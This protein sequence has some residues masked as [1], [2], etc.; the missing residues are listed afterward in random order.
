MDYLV[1]PSAAWDLVEITCVAGEDR[2]IADGT[3]IYLSGLQLSVGKKTY[4]IGTEFDIKAD[5]QAVT[6]LWG[7]DRKRQVR[8]LV[9]RTK[10]NTVAELKA[11]LHQCK[12][13]GAVQ[14]V[15]TSIVN[16]NELVVT[17]NGISS[18]PLVLPGTAGSA[19]QD[20]SGGNNSWM[21]ATGLG[22][23]LAKNPGS[24]L[25][26]ITI[27]DG[28]V[29][30]KVEVIGTV[31]DTGGS[32]GDLNVLFD[33][34]GTRTFN[35][36]AISA[37]KPSVQ[38][39]NGDYGSISPGSPSIVNPNLLYGVSSVGSGSLQVTVINATGYYTTH[40]LTFLMP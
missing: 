38:I 31:A 17:V 40:K 12:V 1:L 6:V 28:V 13:M 23:T 2:E 3:T 5:A 20:Y 37:K 15:E 34:Q 22:V 36:D 10:Y 7:N 21:W 14:S 18:T 11:A 4:Y 32:P 35:Q 24:S 29:P 27:P 8:V 25:Y 26:T 19:I 16:G 30:W 9:A 39:S 33:Y